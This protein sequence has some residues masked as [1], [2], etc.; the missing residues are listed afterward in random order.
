MEIGDAIVRDRHGVSPLA[1][2]HASGRRASEPFDRLEHTH[3]AIFMTQFA[4]AKLLQH[5]GIRPDMLL[6]VSLG[7]FAAMSVAGMVP[8]E[9]ALAAVARRRACSW[10]AARPAR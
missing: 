8:F 10:K 9:T 5:K 6:G 2:I 3:P 7:E 4:M 1:E